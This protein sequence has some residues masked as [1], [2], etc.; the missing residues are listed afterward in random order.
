MSQWTSTASAI[1]R[2]LAEI[3]SADEQQGA[4]DF[5][6]TGLKGTS[7]CAVTFHVRACTEPNERVYLVGS[8]PELGMLWRA[9]VV[10]AH[11]F[12]FLTFYTVVQLFSC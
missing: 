10:R 2:S 11:V 12:I 3:V 4:G 7:R 1:N 6:Q 8:V 9:R 5:D